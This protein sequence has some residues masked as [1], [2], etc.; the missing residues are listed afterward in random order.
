[1]N[2]LNTLKG[3]MDYTSIIKATKEKLGRVIHMLIKQ[4]K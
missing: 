3:L 1:M 2:T 4:T